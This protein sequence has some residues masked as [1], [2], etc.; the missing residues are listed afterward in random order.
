MA[1]D[2]EIRVFGYQC[3]SHLGDFPGSFVFL[4]GANE[5]YFVQCLKDVTVILV[6]AESESKLVQPLMNRLTHIRAVS[7]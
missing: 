7:S 2:A 3:Q 1:H 6:I 4:I 5:I